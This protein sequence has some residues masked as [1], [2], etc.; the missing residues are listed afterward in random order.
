MNGDALPAASFLPC[1]V[2]IGFDTY[3]VETLKGDLPF[4]PEEALD[5]D[6]LA[7]E[8]EN[9]FPMI[10]GLNEDVPLEKTW[11]GGTLPSVGVIDEDMPTNSSCCSM[12]VAAAEGA[13]A[14]TR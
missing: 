1:F 14:K 11:L 7:V 6:P 4:T 8:K 3:P 12:I 10:S 5:G 2:V 13:L 9:M